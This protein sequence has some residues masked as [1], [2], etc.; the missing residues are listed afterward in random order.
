[1]NNYSN[2]LSYSSSDTLVVALGI[3]VVIMIIAY[4]Y[5]EFKEM[6]AVANKKNNKTNTSGE[7]PDYW[8]TVGDNTC[9]NVHKIGKC[10][11]GNDVEF[12]NAMFTHP[13]TGEYMKCRW[14]REC[15]T[16]WEHISKLC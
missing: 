4:T 7:C 6:Q 16:P 9:R 3:F 15:D 10:G 13:R 14:S 2:N 8:E 1:M 5:N 11:H 12:T